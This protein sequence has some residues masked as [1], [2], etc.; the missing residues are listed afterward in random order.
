[1]NA[2]L[3]CPGP[4]LRLFRGHGKRY[5]VLIGVNRG[6]LIVP[7]DWWSA[8]D[9]EVITAVIPPG[10]PRLWTRGDH[11]KHFAEFPPATCWTK[12][13][14]LAGLVLA[15][16]LKADAIDCYGCDMT[17]ADEYD[18]QPLPGVNRHPN[19]WSDERH[20]WDQT[21]AMLPLEITRIL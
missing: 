17:G 7:C 16:I 4:S 18:G 8:I 12:Y 1:L 2:A 13:S 9:M 14:A 21:A 20:W 19:R 15:A 10:K 11:E 3:L 5:D 6:A